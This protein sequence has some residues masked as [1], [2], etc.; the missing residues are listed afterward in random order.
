MIWISKFEP[1]QYKVTISSTI[2]LDLQ[3]TPINCN[4][5]CLLPVIVCFIIQVNWETD[6]DL[7]ICHNWIIMLINSVIDQYL[8]IQ[9]W[10]LQCIIEVSNYPLWILLKIII[11]TLGIYQVSGTSNILDFC[12]WL[13]RYSDDL[14]GIPS[15]GN[16]TSNVH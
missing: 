11:N 13:K 2:F 3:Q 5:Q 8:A 15:L 4:Y 7:F 16:S 10:K 12:M 1:S 14:Y 9:L 6:S